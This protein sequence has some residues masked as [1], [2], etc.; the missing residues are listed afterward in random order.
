VSHGGVLRRELF[1]QRSTESGELLQSA[2]GSRQSD[3]SG[4]RHAA[5]RFDREYARGRPDDRDF[6]LAAHRR[7]S[8]VLAA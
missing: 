5:F 8:R 6:G 4:E 7:R 1:E 2:C 3:Q